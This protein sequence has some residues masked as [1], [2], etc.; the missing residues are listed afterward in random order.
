MKPNFFYTFQSLRKYTQPLGA[1]SLSR[2]S[3]GD[4]R[5]F[6]KM[7][8]RSI[9]T[10]LMLF[11]AV[12]FLSCL[13]EDDL[14]DVNYVPVTVQ[15]TAPTT[16]TSNSA[17]LGGIIS[18][19]QA[20]NVTRGICW[21]TTQNPVVSLSTNMVIGLG[22]GTFSITLTG[23]QPAT[24]YYVR[25]YATNKIDTVYG[26]QKSF[27]TT[28]T[29]ATLTTSIV[30]AI[31][32]TT[33]TCGGAITSNGGAAITVSGVCWSTTASP[34]TANSKT[35]DGSTSVS[36]ISL[37]TGLIPGTT[38]NGGTT[39]TASGV[40]WSTSATPTTANSKTTDGSA[41]GSFTCSLTGLLSGTT[42]YVRA[43][44]TNSEGTAYGNEV[45]FTT[46]TSSGSVTDMDGNVYT[47]VTI[48]TQT[49]MVENLKTTKYSDGT[50]IPL[51]SDGTAWAALSTPGYCYYNN[52]AANKNI[53]G[54]LYNWYA[55]N[56]GKLAP[57]GWHVPT[58]AEWT[59]LE[60]YLIANGY[61]YDGTTSGNKIAK[62]LAASMLWNTS[63]TVGAIGNDLT[64]NNTSGFTALPG[65]YRYSNGTFYSIGNYGNWWSSTEY[66]TTSAWY[67]NLNCNYSN[68]N[69]SVSTKSYGF[70]VRCVRD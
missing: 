67:R 55:V 63:T 44:A 8:A 47:T 38:C 39:I 10:Y 40:C 19:P 4:N 6:Y 28:S 50:S 12:G 31:T 62:A 22:I 1:E 66:S 3:P 17:I 9:R 5:H 20:R 16:I 7:N 58:D 13:S 45:S 34:T 36:F 52:D 46:T 42:Y 48:G 18:A 68:L 2:T 30:T 41:S 59:I 56:T 23:L 37:L 57:T 51:V 24:T 27:T 70:S 43:Y 69:R 49:W 35:T 15:T 65:G 53:Y 33:A 32:P 61:N 14:N 26:T 25:A 29:F 60:N 54:A 64:K 21:S 11:F